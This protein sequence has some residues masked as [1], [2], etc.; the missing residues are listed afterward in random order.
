M[1]S[2][3]YETVTGKI[4][5][6]L[7]AGVAPWVKPWKNTSYDSTGF[8]QNAVSRKSYQGINVLLLMSAAA[9]MGYDSTE[10]VTFKQAQKLG[11]SVRKGEKATPITFWKMMKSSELDENGEKK[12]KDWMMMRQYFVFN[13]EQCD[14]PDYAPAPR[15]P[16]VLSD[17]AIKLID[18]LGV[19][20]K[21]SG[22]NACYMPPTDEITIPHK[23]AF[24]SDPDYYA[25]LFH[26]IIHATGH[27][28]RL[29]RIGITEN[30]HFESPKY[31]FEELIAELGSAFLCAHIGIPGVL[32][33]A[34]YMKSWV[35]HLKHDSKAI[36]RAASQ[37]QKA[38]QMCIECISKIAE[39][40]ID[41]HQIAA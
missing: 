13:T 41:N 38:A 5:G 25:T 6:Q 7:E 26:E 14:L 36:F 37:A 16:V 22:N 32:R 27:I 23:A 31:A 21:H 15:K 33:H 35:K 28:D 8:P 12:S 3:I 39:P 30:H 17:E 20:V 19:T 34:E 10:W 9:E 1:K 18:S 29:A 2:S 40:A 4:V 11:G 24:K